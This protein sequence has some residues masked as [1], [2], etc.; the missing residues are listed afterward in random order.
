MIRLARKKVVFVIVEG[1]SDDEALGVLFNRIFDRNSVFVHIMHRDITSERGVRPDNILS[2]LGNEV[3]TYAKSNHFTSK[4]FQEIIHITDMDGAYV[5][6]EH[7][8]EDPSAKHPVYS[9][10]DIATCS[11]EAIAARNG[12]KRQNLD[13]L[14]SCNQLWGIPYR[15]FYMSCNLDHVLYNKLNSTDAEKEADAYAFALQY[16]NDIAAFRSF[17]LDSD[18]SVSSSYKDSWAFI[19]FGTESLKRHTNLG[20]CFP[21]AL[22]E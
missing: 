16:R 4:D 3:R 11:V 22:Q 18:F 13:K 2:R 14:C 5:A 17:I 6:D 7:I 21:P 15:V 12:Q 9:T 8:V 10:E 19:K 1:P 20:L